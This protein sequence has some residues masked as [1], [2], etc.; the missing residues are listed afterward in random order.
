MKRKEA[1]ERAGGDGGLTVLFNAE[2]PWPAA[3]QPGRSA[4]QLE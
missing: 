3:P 2:P 4:R 1:N